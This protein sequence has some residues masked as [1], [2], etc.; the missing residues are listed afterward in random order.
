MDGVPVAARWSINFR[1]RARFTLAAANR[2]HV[3]EKWF[4]GKKVYVR[5]AH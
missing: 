2:A 5:P 3:I 1:P 4:M